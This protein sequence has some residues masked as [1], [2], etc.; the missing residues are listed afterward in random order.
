MHSPR[1][2]K[3]K[4]AIRY[5]TR[6]ANANAG[7]SK[8]RLEVRGS[9]LEVRGSRL[10]VRGWRSWVR[11]SEQENRRDREWMRPLNEAEHGT[12]PDS[13]LLRRRKAGT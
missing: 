13:F 11:C 10:E 9:T 3:W 7:Y 8:A 5:V 2:L 1:S 6:V 4:I 12:E